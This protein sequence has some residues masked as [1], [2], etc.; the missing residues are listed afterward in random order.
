MKMN[1]GGLIC[2]ITTADS[3]RIRSQIDCDLEAETIR[4]AVTRFFCKSKKLSNYVWES[5]SLRLQK[6]KDRRARRHSCI[7]PAV[8]MELPGK[9][10]KIRFSVTPIG[11]VI[12]QVH[13]LAQLTDSDS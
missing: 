13:I 8:L 9:W 6:G 3:M 2:E 10:V 12:E 11:V 4:Y 7:I 5:Y 1:K